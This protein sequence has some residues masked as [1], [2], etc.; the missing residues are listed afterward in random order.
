MTFA[1]AT[2]TLAVITLVAY[3]LHGQSQQAGPSPSPALTE[4]SSSEAYLHFVAGSRMIRNTGSSAFDSYVELRIVV[5][6][7]GTVLSAVPS[8][9]KSEWYSAATSLA[10]GWQ[11]EPFK[12]AGV[13]IYVTFKSV[14][15][16]VPP[17]RRPEPSYPFPAIKKWD[18]LRISLRRSGCFGTCPIYTLT[19]GGDGTVDYDGQGYVEYCGQYHGHVSQS[20]VRQLV[21]YFGDADFFNLFDRYELNATD[22]PTYTTSIQFDDRAKSVIDYAGERVGMPEGVGNVENQIDRLAGPRLWAN[23]TDSHLDCETSPVPMNTSDV[24]NKIEQR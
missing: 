18:S 21:S 7:S 14:V 17:E 13:P 10:Q 19:V 3:L 23:R 9:G 6:P 11:Y 2:V 24:P 4:V 22:L 16:I 8:S 15:L 20:V 5:T 12:R 1:R